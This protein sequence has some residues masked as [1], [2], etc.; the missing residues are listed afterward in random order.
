MI[1]QSRAGIERTRRRDSAEYFFL[2]RMRQNDARSKNRLLVFISLGLVWFYG[3]ESVDAGTR[4]FF[5]FDRVLCRVACRETYSI[6]FFQ[7]TWEMIRSL[8]GTGV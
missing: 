3:A 2:L 4:E 7:L 6:V 8:W 5:L 1:K